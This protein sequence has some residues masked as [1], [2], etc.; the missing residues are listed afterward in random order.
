MTF[1]D[2]NQAIQECNNGHLNFNLGEVR[3]FLLGNNWYPLSATINRAAEIAHENADLTTD[4][5]LVQ[6]VY[7]GIWMRIEDVTFQNGAPVEM[8]TNGRLREAKKL[9]EAL[10]KITN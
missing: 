3:A 4:R 7:L 5:A 9:A 6:L 2:L 8:D 1:Q 10:I